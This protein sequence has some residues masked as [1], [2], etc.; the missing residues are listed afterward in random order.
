MKIE[1]FLTVNEIDY[2]AMTSYDTIKW[3]QMFSER[4][5]HPRVPFN[6]WVGIDDFYVAC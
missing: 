3:S 6:R 1:K 5:L 4:K 2:Y